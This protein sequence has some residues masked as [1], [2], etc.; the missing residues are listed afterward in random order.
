MVCQAL[1]D[2]STSGINL[3]R[4]N[5]TA[6]LTAGEVYHQARCCKL[7]HFVKTKLRCI[8]ADVEFPEFSELL[9]QTQK[10]N[11]VINSL[12]GLFALY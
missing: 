12:L 8:T 6:V 9:F 3:V 10:N 5:K 4:T 7:F 1:E 2:A 11:R